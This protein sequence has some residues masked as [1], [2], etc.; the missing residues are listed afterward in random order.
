MLPMTSNGRIICCI[1]I[2]ENDGIQTCI[3]IDSMLR[4]ERDLNEG[5]AVRI[6]RITKS[7][8][9]VTNVNLII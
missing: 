4:S 1:C 5:Q 9:V 3:I 7:K 6:L 8:T 2:L